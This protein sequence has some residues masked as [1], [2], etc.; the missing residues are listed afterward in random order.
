MVEQSAAPSAAPDLS[1][2]VSNAYG[3][4]WRNLWKNFAD[5]LLAGIVYVAMTVPVGFII[6][7]IFAVGWRD[8]FSSSLDIFGIFGTTTEFAWH[9]QIVS[10]ILKVFFFKPL[11][12]GMLF[13]FLCA[14]SSRTVD[15]RDLFAG[16]KRH[17][18]NVLLAAALW[19]LIFS[20]P[21]LA[22]KRIPDH[23]SSLGDFLSVVWSGVS[24]VLFCKLG[25]VRFL[26][27]DKQLSAPRAF[28]TSWQ[29]TR[30]HALENF[31]IIVLGALIMI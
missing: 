6:G 12:W 22:I 1:P 3:H 24:I 11:F 15:L 26:V 9:F 30:G 14:A 28:A 27:I 7:L 31:G 25:F 18:S 10:G 16:F 17:Y 29:W 5:L 21:S 4:A 13:L 23:I 19:W 8:S 20:L 2:G